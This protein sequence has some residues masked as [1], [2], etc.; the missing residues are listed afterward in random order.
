MGSSMKTWQC[1]LFPT[2]FYCFKC[3]SK[4]DALVTY[5]FMYSFKINK[6][7]S[8]R[9]TDISLLYMLSS[10]CQIWIAIGTGSFSNAIDCPLFG[11]HIQS[12]SAIPSNKFWDVFFNELFQ[13][14]FSSIV[15]MTPCSHV[16]RLSTPSGFSLSL[17][18]IVILPAYTKQCYAKT[19]N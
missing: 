10:P 7:V 8:H 17:V 11:Y 16:W 3:V 2:G 15:S 4:L 19:K 13:I 6:G 18:L 9:G 14:E 12:Q 5:L 1:Y